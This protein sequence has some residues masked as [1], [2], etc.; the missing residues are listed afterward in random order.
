MLAQRCRSLTFGSCLSP[1]SLPPG[2]GAL[3][4]PPIPASFS[5]NWQQ[6]AGGE[7][8]DPSS[9]LSRG[10][11]GPARAPWRSLGARA[12]S[13]KPE[14]SSLRT[15]GPPATR[16]IPKSLAPIPAPDPARPAPLVPAPGAARHFPGSALG[17]ARA[18]RLRPPRRGPPLRRPLRGRRPRIP[19]S[20]RALS[21]SGALS[22]STLELVV[23]GTAC[24][25]CRHQ[26]GL[27]DL[28]PSEDRE[29]EDWSA[30]GFPGLARPPGSCAP[31]PPRDTSLPSAARP[32]GAPGAPRDLA[33]PGSVHP[34][35]RAQPRRPA[36]LSAL[37]PSQGSARI[38]GL[39]QRCAPLLLPALSGAQELGEVLTQ[40]LKFL[41]PS[42]RTPPSLQIRPALQ[43]SA[44]PHLLLLGAGARRWGLQGARDQSLPGGLARP[45]QGKGQSP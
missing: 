5:H 17:P 4:A 7:A 40:L 9:R 22:P 14:E 1:P 20:A 6:T 11:C 42:S 33:R 23:P 41:G 34:L 24:R 13:T 12:S 27:P 18:R 25:C 44:A 43:R 16:R 21:P 45:R 32:A 19:L 38:S 30:R 35:P 2:S 8:C 37:R 10:D 29:L 26:G 3:P 31:A 36:P 39:T 15:P 28:G